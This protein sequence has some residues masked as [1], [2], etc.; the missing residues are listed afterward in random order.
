VVPES[1]CVILAEKLTK[2]YDGA[3]RP[4]V[5]AIDLRVTRGSVV[6]LVGP[7]GAGKTTTLQLLIGAMRPSAGRIEILGLPFGPDAVQV[8]ARLGYVPS[9][10]HL[11]EH[12]TGEEQTLLSA[13]VYGVAPGTAERR[14]KELFELLELGADGRRRVREYSHGMKRKVSIACALIHDPDLVLLDEPLEG[15][16]VLTARMLKAIFRLMAE[17]GKTLVFTSH[18]L[19]LIDDLCP[20]IVLMHRARLLFDGPTEEL[21]RLADTEARGQLEDAFMT[22]IGETR[23]AAGLSWI[24]TGSGGDQ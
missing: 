16:D 7:N 12:L 11:F 20:R 15:I 14:L 8:K 5:D 6:G 1:D 2:Q 10:D 13:T 4:A 21:K 3:D 23:H 17:R 18:N 22:M 24:T 9:D 19:P